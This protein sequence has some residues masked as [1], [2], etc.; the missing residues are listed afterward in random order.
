[1]MGSA[2]AGT[3]VR[4]VP[5]GNPVAAVRALVG[6][7]HGR[8]DV[9]HSHMTAADLAVVVTAP[10]LRAPLVS[11]LHFAQPRG[12]TPLRR[13]IYRPVASC[14]RRQIAISRFVS[15]TC[16]T[17]TTVVANG[18]PE[19]APHD[20]GRE[21]GREKVVLVAQRLEP[22]K[23]TEV[24]LDAWARASLRDDG[25]RLAIAGRGGEDAALRARAIRLGVA[26]SV[27]FV[28]FVDDVGAAMARASILLA[29]APA[30]PFGLS[31]VEAMA[32][33]TPVVAYRRG[34]MPEVVDEG[35]TGY[36]ALDV[37]SAVAAVRAAVQLDRATVSARA[38]ARFGVQRMVQ[39][40]LRTY[41]G[42][43]SSSSSSSSPT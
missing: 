7:R 12:R 4:F 5:A 39:D 27:D 26:G 2:L 33:G 41:E 24:A 17:P 35:V 6:E 14:F 3:G 32:C 13:A 10:V 8:P 22:E 40:Y 15:E 36:L 43:L 25:W 1:M 29:T 19:P 20:G 21:S 9:V 23:R 34:S 16:A 37:D 31:V 11:T 28:G 38:Q 30:E 42:L 18:V